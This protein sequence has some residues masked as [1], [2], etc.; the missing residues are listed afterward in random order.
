MPLSGVRMLQVGGRSA[1][2][3]IRA[4]LNCPLSPG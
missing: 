3:I 4:C 2:H 1:I